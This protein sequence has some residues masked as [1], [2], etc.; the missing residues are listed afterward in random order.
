MLRD[1]SVHHCL[2]TRNM[3]DSTT[4]CNLHVVNWKYATHK[5]SYCGVLAKA[6]KVSVVIMFYSLCPFPANSLDFDV[7]PDPDFS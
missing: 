3:V 2:V 1:Q 7:I 4:I 5:G 6:L